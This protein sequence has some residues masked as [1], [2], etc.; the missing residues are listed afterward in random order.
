MSTMI[1]N[2]L[3]STHREVLNPCVMVFVGLSVRAYPFFRMSIRP[4]VTLYGIVDF[5]PPV[6]MTW[7]TKSCNLTDISSINP[8]K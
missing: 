3:L 4:P 6:E 1:H 7:P 2:L 8:Y 5:Q